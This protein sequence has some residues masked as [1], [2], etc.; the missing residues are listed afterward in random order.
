MYGLGV[1]KAC[2]SDNWTIRELLARKRVCG[3]LP[4][5]FVGGQTRKLIP[6]MIPGTHGYYDLLNFITLTARLRPLY[7]WKVLSHDTELSGT[8]LGSA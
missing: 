4:G 8:S 3:E 7:C 1:Q 5:T 2:C 6:R